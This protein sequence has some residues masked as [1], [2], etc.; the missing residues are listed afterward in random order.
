LLFYLE[1]INTYE[2]TNFNVS[3]NNEKPIVCIGIPVYNGEKTISRTLNSLEDQT[4]DDFEIIIS[5]NNST[6]STQKICENYAANDNKIKYI[7]HNE[8]KGSFWNF[9]F[10][11]KQSK[12]KYF[13]WVA[14]DDV[15]LPTFLE[16]NV[17]ILDSDK[18]FVGS[19]G[20]TLF[21]NNV[22]KLFPFRN[23]NAFDNYSTNRSFED[24]IKFYLQLTSGINIYS[25]WR[26]D[27]LKK[28]FPKKSMLYFPFAIVL[29]VLKYGDI[30]IIDE[31]LTIRYSV[32]IS[33]TTTFMDRAKIFNENN[34]TSKIFPLYPFTKWC[35][36]TLGLKIFL[37]NL[38]YFIYRNLVIIWHQLFDFSHKR[39]YKLLENL[40]LKLSK[41]NLNDI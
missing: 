19:I 22:G 41:T 4:F 32:G 26:T 28:E 10:T 34:L 36:Q 13:I 9:D 31:T 18:H 6:D 40:L 5:D 33:A 23:G 21:S 29:S 37:K 17:K 38:D 11:L 14:A 15:L 7:R 3:S 12:S 16:K 27:I 24:R 25:L 2:K 35:L 20:K 1:Y 30:N 8:N 39:K